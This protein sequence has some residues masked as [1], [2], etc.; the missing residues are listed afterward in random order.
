MLE[1]L[2]SKALSDNGVTVVLVVVLDTFVEQVL[3]RH[4]GV[5]FMLHEVFVMLMD[6][7]FCL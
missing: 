6:D 4:R 2:T 5:D 7:C 1:G 3:L